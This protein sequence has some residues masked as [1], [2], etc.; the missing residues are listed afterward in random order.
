MSVFSRFAPR[1][2]EAIVAR[3]GWS[4]LRPVQE[5]AGEALL[6]GSNAVILAP[7]AGGEDRS[8][9]VPHALQLVTTSQRAWAPSTSPRS[10]PCSTTRPNDS[11]STPRWSPRPLR[12]ARRH[13]GQSPKKVPERP[14]RPAHDHPESLEVMLVSQ[15][16]NERKDF[17]GPPYRCHRRGTRDCRHRPRRPPESVIERLTQVS[18]HDVQRIGL[19][20]TVGNPEAIL[21][22]LQGTSTRPGRWSTRPS[23][24]PS[25]S[26]WSFTTP[27]FRSFLAMPR[28][29]AK[30]QRASSF[31]QSGQL[32]KLL[33]SSCGVRARKSS[34][35]IARYRRKSAPWLKS[36]STTAPTLASFAPHP[37]ARHRRRDLDRVPQAEAPDHSQLLS[38]A[39]GPNRPPRWPSREHDVLRHERPTRS[40]NPSRLIELA[41][42][43][44]VESIEVDTRCWPVL[45]HQLLAMSLASDG[46]TVDDAWAH[47]S[48]MPDFRDIHRAEFD[49][50]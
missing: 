44:W 32:R 41:R 5:Q 38:A 47:L 43:G 12:L 34:C 42:T 24:P 3:L 1:L 20:A 7:T 10:K 23:N 29:M 19:S 17:W 36:D 48:K 30:G 14:D 31:C 39:Y 35:T 45:I 15:R 27:S 25:A 8:G 9:D 33:Q 37:R 2:Q 11:G 50:L 6:D 28:H 16:V 40:C 49:R 46:I 22:W 21:A 13:D 18:K 4:S 26:Y